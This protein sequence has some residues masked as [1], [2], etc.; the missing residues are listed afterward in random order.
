[1][2]RGGLLGRFHELSV[3]TTDIA[4]SVEFYERLGFTQAPTGDTWPHPYGVVSDGRIALG[5]HQAPER[6]ALTFVHPEVAAHCALLEQHGLALAWR[7]TDRECFNEVGFTAPG[8]QL[9]MLIEA[10]TYSPPQRGSD[11]HSLCGEFSELSLPVPDLDEAARYWESLGLVALEVSERPWPHRP[12]AADHLSLSLHPAALFA[13]PLL[14][15]AEA[16]MQRRLQRLSELGVML[17]PL[18]ALNAA[19]N[20]LLQAPEGTLLALTDAE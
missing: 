7:R 12:L 1:V 16:G 3:A 9:V 17:R 10:R 20:A 4:A 6:S 5:L 2:P 11:E 13:R 8:G 19:A 14:V 15:F 18:R